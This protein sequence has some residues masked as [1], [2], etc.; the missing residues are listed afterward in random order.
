MARPGAWHWFD[1]IAALREIQRVLRPGGVLLIVNYCYLAEHSPVARDTETL[2]LEF[3]PAWSMSGWN[4]LFPEQ[5]DA[6]I[7]GGFR[8]VEQFCFDYPEHFSHA[9]WRGRVRTC[10]GVG[11]GGLTP[12]QVER[13]DAALASLLTRKYTDPVNVEHRLWSVVGRKPA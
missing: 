2:I 7:R 10:N 6:M 13:F 8:L 3:N 12:A 9:R 1:A 5:I 11:S 4:G